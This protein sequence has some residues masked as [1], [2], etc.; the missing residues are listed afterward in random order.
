MM[1]NFMI[2]SVAA[3]VTQ[4]AL[5]QGAQPKP[6]DI[7]AQDATGALN[8]WSKQA[9][10]QL[11]F[12]YDSLAG[13]RTVALRGRYAPREALLRLLDGLPLRVASEN[14]SMVALREI[15]AKA[16]NAVDVSDAAP[17]GPAEEIVVTG[18]NTKVA[19]FRAPYSVSSYR[20]DDIDQQSPLSTADLIGTLPGFYAEATSGEVSATVYTRGLPLGGYRFVQLLEDGLPIFNENQEGTILPDVFVRDDLMTERVE[21][22]RL[23]T[24]PILYNNAP[25]GVINFITRTGTDVFKGAIRLT[26]QDNDAQRIDGFLSGPLADRLSF[27]AGGF[28]RVGDGLRKTGFT[29]DKGGQ[30]RANVTYRDERGEMTV[31]AKYQNDRNIFYLPI[32]LD[33]PRD[34][35]RS[36]KDLIDPLRGTLSSTNVQF[37]RLRMVDGTPTGTTMTRDLADGRHPDV[38]TAG[39]DARFEVGKITF[40]NLF[41]VTDGTLSG[42]SLFSTSAVQDATA[43][44]TAALARA[45]ST[46][47]TAVAGVRYAYAD[48]ATP[49]QQ[50]FDPAT[51]RN[52]VVQAQYQTAD[53]K[54]SNVFDSLSA[55]GTV[56]TGFG[57]H[58]LSVGGYYSR[59]DFDQTQ[60]AADMLFEVRNRPRLLDLIAVDAAGQTLG[61]VTDRGVVRYGA[62]TFVGGGVEGTALAFYVSDTWRLGKLQID[63]GFRHQTTKQSG[64]GI[65]TITQNLGTRE[66]LAD[67]A[68]IGSAGTR[69][70]RS[71]RFGGNSYTVGGL[72]EFADNFVM[73]ARY[74]RGLLTPAL[75]N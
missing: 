34:P 19:Q 67:D 20:R 42:D 32:P 73:F 12:P 49:G 26:A 61:S 39:A 37:P 27:A 50:A 3:I 74:T 11:L 41:R 64:Y 43:Y 58:E 6:F 21:A 36:L 23:G 47:G 7:P 59:Y 5:A 33:D 22:V 46:F 71:E 25:G 31:Y 70:N 8:R 1:R 4:P 72:Y 45:R 2:L 24:S 15:D 68:V 30:L 60:Y 57:S 44:R 28:Y 10:I 14:V 13:R 53:T 52:L 18:T 54:F 63:A 51:T 40:R 9:G 75:S 17:G 66:T 56:E 62:S 48:T 55:R 38:F 29:A 16:G 69:T 35:S 65:N